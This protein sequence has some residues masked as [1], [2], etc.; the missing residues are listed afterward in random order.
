VIT[1]AGAG[2]GAG[3]GI[4]WVAATGW[5]AGAGAQPAKLRSEKNKAAGAKIFSITIA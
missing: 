2:G 5:Q 1:G 4:G 3:T